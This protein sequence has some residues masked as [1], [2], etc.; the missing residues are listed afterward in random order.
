MGDRATGR[1]RTTDR[2]RNGGASGSIYRSAPADGDCPSADRQCKSANW[3]HAAE[4]KSQY[5]GFDAECNQ[6]ERGESEWNAEFH[7]AQRGTQRDKSG[8]NSTE[9][10]S[11]AESQYDTA[12]T[13]HQPDTESGQQS[14]VTS[15]LQRA[16]AAYGCQSSWAGMLNAAEFARKSGLATAR[17]FSVSITDFD[18]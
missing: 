12:S 5:A 17:L 16:S 2:W 3:R 18:G 8:Y 6:S 4:S 15:G 13:E 9:H 1:W 10:N 7:T 11:N 14:A